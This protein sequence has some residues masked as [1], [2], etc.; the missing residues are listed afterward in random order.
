MRRRYA[1]LPSI[2][3]A[4]IN[5]G[6][7]TI[8][9]ENGTITQVKFNTNF[10]GAVPNCNAK[11]ITDTTNMFSDCNRLTSI[12]KLNWN[13]TSIEASTFSYCTDLTNF[14]IPESVTTIGSSAFYE[15]NSLE[16]ITIPNGV[17][18]IGAWAFGWCVSLP[19]I[20]IPG[21][22]TTIGQQAFYGC[23]AIGEIRSYSMIAPTLLGSLVF[24][25]VSKSIPLYIPIGSTG[26]DSG[27]WAQFT[28]KIYF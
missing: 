23:S 12:P 6:Y 26:Y 25:Y 11:S 24:E 2:R 13:I 14:T 15:C 3:Q 16:S 4:W 18:S 27:T 8:I 1:T 22:I 19:S 21:Q 10:V 9:E 7:A 28:N 5:P 20:V 17:T